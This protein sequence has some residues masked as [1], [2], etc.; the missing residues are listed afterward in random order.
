MDPATVLVAGAR[1][2]RRQVAAERAKDVLENHQRHEGEGPNELLDR[3]SAALD[4]LQM[5]A[6]DLP[7]PLQDRVLERTEWMRYAD[8]VGRDSYGAGQHYCPFIGSCSR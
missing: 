2:H 8:D 1:Q 6:V 4:E 7:Q 5:L 3:I